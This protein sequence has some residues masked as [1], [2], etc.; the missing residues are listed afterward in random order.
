[1]ESYYQHLKSLLSN[2]CP[3]EEL[4]ATV[5]ALGQKLTQ[6]SSAQ[7]LCTPVQLTA[8]QEQQLKL[9]IEQLSAGAPLQYLVGCIEDDGATF[10]V[11]KRALIP[12]PETAELVGWIK[13]CCPSPQSIVDIGTG[14]GYIAIQLARHY[15]NAKVFAY[16]VSNDALA[17]AQ[18]NAC[19]NGVNIHFSNL[20][21]LQHTVV[22]QKFDIVVSNPPYILQSEAKEMETR[23]LNYEPHL[24]L[25]VPDTEPL[26]F[27]KAITRFA[28]QHLKPQGMLFFEC[29]RA[30]AHNVAELLKNNGFRQCTVRSDAFGNDRM[31]SGI[32]EA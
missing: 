2:S 14:S 27:Y 21:I 18:E 28:Q 17:L 22:D 11:D 16:D 10:K 30:Y 12:R 29:N 9:W 3:Q 19:I 31:V 6:L 32:W 5:F 25:F 4:H 20:D 24:A 1:M 13:E 23:V 26:L 15:S 8:E 7:L